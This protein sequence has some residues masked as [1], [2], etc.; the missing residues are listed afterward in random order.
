SEWGNMTDDRRHVL[1]INHEYELPLGVGHEFVNRG[2][3]AQVIG[4]WK[5][6]GI[7]SA[8]TGDHFTPTSASA[9]SNSTGGGGDRPNRIAD[10][11]FASD[12]QSIDHWFDLAAFAS[13]AQFTFGNA[14]RGILIGP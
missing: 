7:W 2:L 14:G 10:G 6:T 13:P 3:L 1:V 9:A 5:V 11:N 8:S 4:N 12:R